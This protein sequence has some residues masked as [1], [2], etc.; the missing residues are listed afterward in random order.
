MDGR[1]TRGLKAKMGGEC[2]ISRGEPR[3]NSGVI[4]AG[5]FRGGS[6][7]IVS[8]RIRDE[9]EGEAPGVKAVKISEFREEE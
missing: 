3:L 7:N 9:A 2:C 8:R 6:H 4:Q 1:G 5:G